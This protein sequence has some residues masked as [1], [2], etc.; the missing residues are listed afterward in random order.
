M[1][2]KRG[3]S[4]G[5]PDEALESLARTLYPDVIEYLSSE[6]GKKDYEEWERE[7]EKTKKGKNRI[8]QKEG[9]E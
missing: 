5:I 9:K 4:L 6:M 7:K 8:R 1:S 2:K 3:N